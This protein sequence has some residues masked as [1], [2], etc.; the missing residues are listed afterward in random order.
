MDPLQREQ[1][2]DGRNLEARFRLY[3]RFSTNPVGLQPL[4]LAQIEWKPQT[5]VLEPGCGVGAFWV[6]N[7]DRIPP[8]W[9]VTLT[10]FSPGMMREVERR[11]NG[12]RPDFTFVTVS[13]EEL[14][15]P[16]RHV[17]CGVRPFHALS[18]Q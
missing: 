5:S 16:R 9:R 14:P 10:D 1:C 18:R 6:T 11:L 17:R 4:L 2:R 8:G 7:R 13:A 3:E 15:Y 12:V